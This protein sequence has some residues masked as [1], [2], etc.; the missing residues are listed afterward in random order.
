MS[1]R[2]LVVGAGVIGAASAHYLAEAGLSVTLID[3]GTFGS[4]CSHGNCGYVCPS[5]VL[6]F[7]APGALRSTLKTLLQK[8]SPL[9]V[10]FRLDPALWGWFLRFMRRCN[11]RDLLAAGHAIHALL[12]SSRSLY[13]D[14]FQHTLKNVEW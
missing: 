8:N 7:A 5:H 4:G 10:R 2:V 14:L 9:K 3:Q 1:E 6:P 12:A 11:Q 13:D